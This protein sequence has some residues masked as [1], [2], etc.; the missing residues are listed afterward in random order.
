V[1]ED[2]MCARQ[3]QTRATAACNDNGIFPV[4]RRRTPRPVSN[5]LRIA[6]DLGG[7]ITMSYV[8]GGVLIIAPETHQ[9]NGWH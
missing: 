6:F 8:A 1:E 4:L 7:P 9:A 2:A 5:I 3:T